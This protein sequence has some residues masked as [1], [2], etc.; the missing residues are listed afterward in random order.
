MRLGGIFI[1]AFLEIY[2]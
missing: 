1:I 2:C